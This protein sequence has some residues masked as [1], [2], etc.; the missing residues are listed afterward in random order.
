MRTKTKK[1]F[2]SFSK[3]LILHRKMGHS[4]R[5][6]DSFG[7]VKWAVLK[8]KMGHFASVKNVKKIQVLRFQYF[9]KLS[10][11]AHTRPSD[12]NFRTMALSEAQIGLFVYFFQKLAAAPLVHTD[13]LR[14]RSMTCRSID[15]GRL[16]TRQNTINSKI[17]LLLR[18]LF[19][20]LHQITKSKTCKRKLRTRSNSSEA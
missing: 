19:V 3:W 11:F 8:C 20:T 10:K 15:I 1:K 5:Q 7:K 4:A 18:R 16:F 12:F 2:S 13:T 9:I 14:K 6:N 17:V